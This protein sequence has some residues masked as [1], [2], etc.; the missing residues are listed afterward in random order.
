VPEGPHLLVAHKFSVGTRRAI[1]IA[2]GEAIDGAALK[3]LVRAAVALNLAK[4]A[5]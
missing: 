3:A 2:E 5:S 4:R 1:D